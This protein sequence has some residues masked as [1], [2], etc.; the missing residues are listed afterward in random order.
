MSAFAAIPASA[1]TLRR[2]ADLVAGV[3]PAAVTAAR[4]TGT[5]SAATVDRE[6]SSR[7]RR[8][9]LVDDQS[10]IRTVVGR[11]LRRM[12]FDVVEVDGAAAAL[13]LGTDVLGALDLL[14]TDVMMPGMQGG[15]LA[16]ILTAE[17]PSLRVLFISGMVDDPEVHALLERPGT[18]FLAKPFG[19]DALF[20]SI[21]EVL[22][23]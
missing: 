11:H 5:L 18:A 23:S 21:H 14:V 22:D 17:H 20:A 13:A 8:V 19:L 15:R 6:A 7:P 4:G 1:G 12:G 16:G 10:M 3:G 2:P 9:L